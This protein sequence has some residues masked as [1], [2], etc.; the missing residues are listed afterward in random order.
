MEAINKDTTQPDGIPPVVAVVDEKKDF[1]QSAKSND[2]E[3]TPEPKVRPE[4]EPAFKDYA[5]VFTYATK[6]DIL[7]YIV[8][9][10]ASIAAGITL[11]LMNSKMCFH[12]NP[13]FLVSNTAHSHL[14]TACKR[15]QCIFSRK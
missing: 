4:R 7:A 2:T 3:P 14:W 13:F 1:D 5:R 8:G 15:L 11:P 12:H 6:W 10:L 9:G